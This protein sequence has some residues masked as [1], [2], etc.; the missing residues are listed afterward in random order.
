M[1]ESCHWKRDN[2]EEGTTRDTG[3]CPKKQGAKRRLRLSPGTA[4]GD[5]QWIDR[6]FRPGSQTQRNRIVQLARQEEGRQGVGERMTPARRRHR[7]GLL[8]EFNRRRAFASARDVA[9]L[10]ETKWRSDVPADEECR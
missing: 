7:L 4:P 3:T 10:P 6:A 2:H 5:R 1:R 9:A 8:P